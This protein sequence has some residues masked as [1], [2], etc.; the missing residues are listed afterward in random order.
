MQALSK[1]IGDKYCVV[2]SLNAIQSKNGFKNEL[3]V[4]GFSKCI[5]KNNGM[6]IRA[7][8]VASDVIVGDYRDSFFETTILRKPA[9]STAYDYEKIIKALNMS[10]HANAFDQNLFCP[11]VRT[12]QELA[13][14]LKQIDHYDYQ[15]MDQFRE[16]M[17]TNCDG[18]SMERVRDYLLAHYKDYDN[19]V[20]KDEQKKNKE[21][22]EKYQELKKVA[23]EFAEAYELVVPETDIVDQIVLLSERAL[24]KNDPLF[25]LKE[26]LKEQKIS[27]KVLMLDQKKTDLLLLARELAI[28]R[29]IVTQNL[30]RSC[31]AVSFGRKQSRSCC[32]N[33][34]FHYIRKSFKRLMRSD[35]RERVHVLL[36]RIRFRCFRFR[37][38]DRKICSVRPIPEMEMFIVD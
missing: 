12:E 20:T 11:I 33:L 1:L 13:N 30:F 17:F 35:G 27:C 14:Q 34:H 25:Q 5:N 38:K 23:D 32:R 9:Y 8:M 21:F 22:Y 4:E 7:L 2:V 10:L 37:L 15:K 6:T 36:H 18:H 16:K 19:L 26:Y 28:A 3:E 24:T 31:A 29:Y